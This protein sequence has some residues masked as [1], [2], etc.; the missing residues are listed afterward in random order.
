MLLYEVRPT[1]RVLSPRNPQFEAESHRRRLGRS[2]LSTRSNFEAR[3]LKP[4]AVG[5]F[6][7]QLKGGSNRLMLCRQSSRRAPRQGDI[8]A[9]PRQ[10]GRLRMR[11]IGRLERGEKAPTLTT[12]EAIA[13]ALSVEPP[14]L[15]AAVSG[16]EMNAGQTIMPR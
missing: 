6:F 7:W 14:E 16:W 12:V 10:C 1:K 8:A 13:N 5:P 11:Y 4:F 15:L 2:A 9:R 3:P